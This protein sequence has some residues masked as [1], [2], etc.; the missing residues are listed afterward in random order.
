MSFFNA[1]TGLMLTGIA[2]I[3]LCLISLPTLIHVANDLKA[4][5]YADVLPVRIMDDFNLS[6][7]SG[8]DFLYQ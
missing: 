3:N 2:W 5:E 1:R 4:F 6:N 8:L 7:I